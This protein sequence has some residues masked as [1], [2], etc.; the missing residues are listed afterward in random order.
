MRNNLESAV[1]HVHKLPV[2]TVHQ[3]KPE[4]FSRYIVKVLTFYSVFQF[5]LYSSVL[6]ESVFC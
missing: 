1:E 6:I 5:L 2:Y 3:T 4:I